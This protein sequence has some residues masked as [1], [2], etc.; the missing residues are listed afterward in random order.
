[1][2][3]ATVT[4]QPR[5]LDRNYGADPPRTDRSQQTFEAR[6]IDAASRAAEIIVDN[7]DR[8]PAELPSTIV[9]PV[10]TAS[11]HRDLEQQ[12]FDQRCQLLLV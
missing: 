1:M 10:L 11:R 7:F 8:G 4:G 3:V 12:G 5:R 2:P 6:S 9:E